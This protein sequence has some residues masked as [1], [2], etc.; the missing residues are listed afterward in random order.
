MHPERE[1]PQR[2]RP[3]RSTRAREG[4]T[5]TGHRFP[6]AAVPHRLRFL[7]G[8]PGS[9]W[10]SFSS[11][12]FSATRP[13]REG[14]PRRAAVAKLEAAPPPALALHARRPAALAPPCVGRPRPAATPAP[15]GRGRSRAAPRAGSTSPP[16]R[17]ASRL[18]GV[19]RGGAPRG[20]DAARAVR[21]T[22][23]ALLAR[24][25]LQ[26][27]APAGTPARTTCRAHVRRPP[28]LPSPR[29]PPR[30]PACC[31]SPRTH[32]QPRCRR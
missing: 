31:C 12:A 5:D 24:R 25:H 22:A 4:K 14:L 9:A 11:T 16:R 10:L 8:V 29:A 27:V 7:W 6:G 26:V 2:S 13:P 32:R 3:P 17:T 15:L 19:R 30:P 28:R 18:R 1:A 23:R 20:A 21:S